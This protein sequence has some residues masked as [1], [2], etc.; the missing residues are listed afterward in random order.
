MDIV[1]ATSLTPLSIALFI[2]VSRE[3][4]FLSFMTFFIIAVPIPPMFILDNLS[5][6][7][8]SGIIIPNIFSIMDFFGFTAFALRRAL[9]PQK[10]KNIVTGL[11]IA[12]APLAIMKEASTLSRSPLNTIIVLPCFSEAA[13][14]AFAGAPSS[15]PFLTYTIFS[16]PCRSCPT[17][18]F[19]VLLHHAP[20]SAAK[21]M[22]VAD[23]LRT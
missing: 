11:P 3:S 22:S 1:Q 20:I 8:P 14:S 10:V 19:P 18:V 9:S 4:T 17:R 2:S 12:A 16:L 5:L 15:L 23:T 6:L 21:P 13:S 7:L